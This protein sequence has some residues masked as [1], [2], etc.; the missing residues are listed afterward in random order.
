MAF[1]AA[2]EQALVLFAGN[3]FLSLSSSE[4][5]ETKESRLILN[6][7]LALRYGFRCPRTLFENTFSLGGHG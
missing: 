6:L 7:D 5:H 4:V 1:R 3:I 2:P